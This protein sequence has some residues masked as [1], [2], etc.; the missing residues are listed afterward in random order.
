MNLHWISIKILEVS[1]M[2]VDSDPSGRLIT[3]LFTS[4]YN[5]NIPKFPL[6]T[7][8]C[9]SDMTRETIRCAC[10]VESFFGCTW[11]SDFD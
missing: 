11:V 9:T 6:E 2:H 10:F 5:T 3:R 8:T 7:R 1:I 4:Q